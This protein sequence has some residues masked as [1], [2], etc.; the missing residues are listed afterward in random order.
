VT[1]GIFQ[2]LLC[3]KVSTAGSVRRS[4]FFKAK[5]QLVRAPMGVTTNDRMLHKRFFRS[6]VVDSK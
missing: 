1:P 3:K 5:K 4:P 2:C 6:L